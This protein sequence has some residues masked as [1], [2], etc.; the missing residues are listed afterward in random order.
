ML[1]CCFTRL[2]GIKRRWCFGM[3]ELILTRPE[4]ETIV[5]TIA[6]Q[7]S[8]RGAAAQLDGVPAHDSEACTSETCPHHPS[9]APVDACSLHPTPDLCRLARLMDHTLLKPDAARRQVER[10][11][12]EALQFSFAAA[13]VNPFWTPLV[14]DRLR[15][16]SVL[17]ATVVGFPLGATFTSAKRAEAE[18]A[19]V[20][21]AQEIDMV[22]NVGALCSGDLTCV[23]N[24]IRGVVE[25]C[26]AMGARL[27]VI[28]ENAYLTDQQKISAC[29][30]AEEAGADYVKTSTGFGPS[31]A[32]A[33]DVRLMR[34]A[35]GS[36][37][38]VKAAGGIRTLSDALAML[39]AGATRL[40][41]SA[42]VA[43]LAEA[44]HWLD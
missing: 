43:I 9:P 33:A 26:H 39:Q 36:T 3:Q 40:G 23:Q 7:L 30:L 19:I 6:L 32:K 24:D 34:D 25:V 22:M 2:D 12:E 37:T 27:K 29:R 18:A 38:G 10:L 11:A 8:R 5:A 35:V 4:L 28:L 41:T 16:S 17:V 20:A 1:K 14:A 21:G 42:S 44:A 13:C 31:G 15:G